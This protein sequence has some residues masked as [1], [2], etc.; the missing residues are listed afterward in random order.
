MEQGYNS[1]QYYKTLFATMLLVVAY[2]SV[3]RE[4][5]HDEFEAVHTSWKMING[6]SIYLDFFQ[7]HHPFFYYLIAPVIYLLGDSITTLIVL[8]LLMLAMYMGIVLCVY[9]LAIVVFNNKKVAWL[10]IAFLLFMAMFSQKAIEIRPDVPQVLF[11]LLGILFLLQFKKHSTL[12]KYFLSAM[13]LALSYLFLQKAVFIVAAIGLVQLFW[14][15]HRRLNFYQLIQYWLI[16][17]FTISP[18]YFYLFYTDQFE[19]YLLYNWIINMHFEGCFSPFNTIVDSFYYNHFIWIFGAVGIGFCL[20]RGLSDISLLGV[21][22]FLTVFA[23]KAPYRQYFMPFVPILC[24]TAAYAM[25]E[26]LRRKHLL[27]VVSLSAIVPML[28]LIRTVIVYPNQPQLE[29]IEWVLNQTDPSDYVYDGDIYFNLYRKDI[30]YFWFSTEPGRGGLGT[31]QSLRPY[32]Y[33]IYDAIRKYQPKVIS[34]TF[35]ENLENDVIRNNY[36][37]TTQYPEL[38]IRVK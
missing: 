27:I 38:Y 8:R 2:L 1:I 11:G 30:D 7:H 23:V 15:Y 4:F 37:Q 29:K 20:K 12:F 24:I 33:N 16:F 25:I 5:D 9:Q 34:D 22:L 10:S 3:A 32:T 6:E 31:Y 36:I 17:G 26:V 18:Y 13:C 19:T 35:V 21:F 28:Y 14:L